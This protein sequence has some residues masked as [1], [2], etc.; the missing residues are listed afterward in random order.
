MVSVSGR[1]RERGKIEDGC[2]KSINKKIAR[3]GS[4]KS[5]SSDQ[6]KIENVEPN[7]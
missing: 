5:W 6:R 2:E 1:R 4:I 3:V 7:R